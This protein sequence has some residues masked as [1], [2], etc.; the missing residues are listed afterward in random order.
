M[1]GDFN[2]EISLLDDKVKFGCLSEAHPDLPLTLDYIPPVGSGQGLAG[3]EVLICSFAGCVSTA[4][5][6]LLRRAGADIKDFKAHAAGYRKEKPLM[7]EKIVYTAEVTSDKATDEML[8][9]ILAR[10]AEISPVWLCLNPSIAVETDF[11]LKK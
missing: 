8:Q 1:N 6:G 4:V 9:N 7:L 10:A 2:I 11:M 5:V 3:L